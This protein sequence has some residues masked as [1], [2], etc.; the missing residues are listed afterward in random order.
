MPVAITAA[1]AGA[2]ASA[3]AGSVIGS[4]LFGSAFAAS[5]AASAIG[6]LAAVGVDLRGSTHLSPLRTPAETR[7][8]AAGDVVCPR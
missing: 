6:G 2:A 1:V 7:F 5:L 3:A 4:T 8:R